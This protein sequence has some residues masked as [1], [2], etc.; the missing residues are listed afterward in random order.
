MRVCLGWVAAACLLA[1]SSSGWAQSG[2]KSHGPGVT[3]TEIKLGQTVPYSGPVSSSGALGRAQAAYFAMLNA[4]GGINGRKITLI[5]LDD[6]YSPPKTVEQT[7]KLVEQEEVLAIVGSNGSPTG[8]AVQA[9]L[10]KKRV[11]QLFQASGIKRFNDPKQFP[12]STAFY[13]P[14]TVE[15]AAFGRFVLRTRPDAKIAVLSPND[16]LGR[17]YVAGFRAALGD[18]ADKM[19]VKSV[20]YDYASPT[21]DS[22]MAQLA[23]SGADVFFNVSMAKFASQ[24]IRK[25]RELAWG[26]QIL[27]PSIAASIGDVLK[28]AG[29]DNAKGLISGRWMKDP[30]APEQADDP[31][32]REYLAFMKVWLPGVAAEQATFALGYNVAQLTEIVIRKCGDDLTRENFIRQATNLK[33]IELPL[34]LQGVKLSNSPEDFNLL[35]ETRFIVFDGEK[36]VTLP[37]VAN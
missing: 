19:I 26:A 15:G 20:T 35:R 12:W 29:L 13:F 8:L 18:K 11:P 5:S 33:D 24:S 17:E 16:E 25:A 22:E 28:P 7:R 31:G 4:K 6:A 36:W 30:S 10:N 27:S 14:F 34:G 3:D 1:A 23:A 2:A 9:Y 37:D 32:V 21:I